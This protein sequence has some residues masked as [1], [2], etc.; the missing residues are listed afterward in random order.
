MLVLAWPAGAQAAG[1]RAQEETVPEGAAQYYELGVATGG[2]SVHAWLRNANAVEALIRPRGGGGT[3][4]TLQSPVNNDA[5]PR[6]SVAPDGAAAAIWEHADHPEVVRRAPGAPFAARETLGPA[7]GAP[8]VAVLDDGSTWAAWPNGATIVVRRASRGGSFVAEPDV[9]PPGAALPEDVRLWPGP[10]DQLLLTYRIRTSTSTSVTLATRA[11]LKAATSSGF[12]D[13]AELRTSTRNHPMGSPPDIFFQEAQTAAF[14]DDV[15]VVGIEEQFA[16][17]FSFSPMETL[18]TGHARALTAAPAPWSSATLETGSFSG[19]PT[20]NGDSVGTPS[21]TRAAGGDVLI[22]WRYSRST[23]GSAAESHIRLARRTGPGGSFTPDAPLA[24]TGAGANTVGIPSLASL[25]GGAVASVFRDQGPSAPLGSRLV[26]ADGTRVTLDTGL[27]GDDGGLPRGHDTFPFAT[28]PDGHALVAHSPSG[29]RVALRAL[30]VLAPSLTVSVPARAVEDASVQ[31]GSTAVDDLGTATVRWDLGDGRTAQGASPAVTWPTPGAYVVTATADDGLGNRTTAT[32]TITVDAAPAPPPGTP[33]PIPGPRPADRTAPLV[34][35][36]TLSRSTFAVG[37]EPT[38]LAA[39]RRRR[40][41]RGTTLSFR[42]SEPA[43]VLV[44]VER[45]RRGFFTGRRGPCRSKRPRTRARVRRCTIYSVRGTLRRTGA[46]G[47]NR[48]AFS[49][50]L[51]RRAL[52][53]GSYR[54]RVV[55]IDA[56]NNVSRPALKS[57]RIVRR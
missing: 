18:V 40:T 28:S 21:A 10:D 22:A 27:A 38:A 55:A 1:W 30:D 47:A 32:R 17:N 2:E 3:R 45:A 35:A 53:R 13:D 12:G 16:Q 34:S 44:V 5:I 31:L 41:P 15:V 6:L 25:P 11:V 26:R 24:S 33:F 19:F 8:D 51:G 23:S 50:R 42:L 29:D 4:V 7:T 57:F 52:P 39:Q 9:D 14:G 37:P 54:L 48:V 20:T 49:G 56:A 36:L 43:R 46:A